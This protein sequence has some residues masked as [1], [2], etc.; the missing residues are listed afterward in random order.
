MI[1]FVKMLE[2][3]KLEFKPPHHS[4]AP[5]TTPMPTSVVTFGLK[6]PLVLGCRTHRRWHCLSDKYLDT[7]EKYFVINLF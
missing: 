6:S 1:I 7:Q 4:R 3:E 5:Y 2:Y